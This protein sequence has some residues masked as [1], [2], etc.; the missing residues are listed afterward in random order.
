[1]AIATHRTKEYRCWQNMKD[2]VFNKSEG[3]Y[4]KYGKLGMFEDWISSFKNFFI[5][6]GPQPDKTTRWSLG[7]IDNTKGYYP[8]NVRWENDFLQN[9]NRSKTKANTS[10]STGVTWRE[11]K[12]RPTNRA[13]ATW[14]D[15]SGVQR[16][17]SFSDKHIGKEEAIRLATEFR[18]KK[19]EELRELGA[20]YGEHHGE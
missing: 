6:I 8:G 17:K 9:R 4:A 16:C 18:A 10:G 12:N 14:Y 19:I 3:Y 5:Y 11:E 13:V 20:E 2:R 15:L 1:M 7:R